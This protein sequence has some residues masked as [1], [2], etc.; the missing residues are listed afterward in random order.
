MV[1]TVMITTAL[2]LLIM[3]MISNMTEGMKRDGNTLI[4]YDQAISIILV[5]GG[6][7]LFN[8][9]QISVKFDIKLYERMRTMG[10]SSVQIKYVVFYQTI[11]TGIVGI[12]MGLILGC[13]FGKY[14]NNVLSSYLSKMNISLNHRSIIFTALL[15]LASIIISGLIPAK[16]ASEVSTAETVKEG[17]SFVSTHK[18]KKRWFRLPFLFQ[19]SLVSLGRNKTRSVI[20]IGFM[21]LGLI[22]LSCVYVIYEKSND[23]IDI[24]LIL[25]SINIFVIGLFNLINTMIT[26]ITARRKEFGIMQSLGMT[27]KQLRTLLL[28][29][30]MNHAVITLIISYFMSYAMISTVIKN[31]FE[32]QW[33]FPHSLVLNP[34]LIFTP[35]ILIITLGIPLISYLW[36][37]K[38]PP[39]KRME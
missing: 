16:V 5:S 2:V 12:L 27:K 18:N 30:G 32:G 14:S 19:L 1:L 10:S 25:V 37:V 39:I 21:A 35:V 22:I 6:V 31:Y 28:F 11:I 26:A 7:I 4:L 13:G 29:E 33:S 17:D 34:F 24:V 20:S 15:M 8:I 9:M 38:E 36:V 3:V 23:A